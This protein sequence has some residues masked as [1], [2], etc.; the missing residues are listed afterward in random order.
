MFLSQGN[1]RLHHEQPVIEMFIG[2]HDLV[3]LKPGQGVGPC[4]RALVSRTKLLRMP[5]ALPVPWLGTEDR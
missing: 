5:V 3:V 1:H 4:S 2:H